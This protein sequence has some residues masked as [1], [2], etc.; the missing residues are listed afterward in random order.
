MFE[1]HITLLIQSVA[2]IKRKVFYSANAKCI[3]IKSF[4]ANSANF[5]NFCTSLTKFFSN[6]HSIKTLNSTHPLQVSWNSSSIVHTSVNLS[7]SSLISLWVICDLVTEKS[8][9]TSSFFNSY[10]KNWNDDLVT[11]YQSMFQY[12][13]EL[14][15]AENVILSQ[16]L[17]EKSKVF[18]FKIFFFLVT[19]LLK[20]IGILILL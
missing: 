10:K 9:N 11:H 4:S 3:Q 1:T 13:L 5:L 20:F 6:T 8:S 2:L 7:T 19:L 16:S 18:I 12:E 14:N 17:Q 15:L